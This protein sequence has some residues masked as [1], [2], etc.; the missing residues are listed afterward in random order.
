M[1]HALKTVFIFFI[2]ISVYS[3]SFV[4]SKNYFRWPV[5]VKPGIVAN[6]GELREGHW[7]MGLDIR[8]DHKVNTPVYA[9]AEGYIARVSVHAFGYGQAIYIN[10]PNGLTTVYGH[11]NKFFPALDSFVKLQQYRQ[12][13]WD[14]E[15]EFSKNELPVKKGQFIALSGSTGSSQGP[16]VHFEIRDTKTERCINPLLFDLPVADAVAPV[17]TKLAMYNRNLS[18]YDQSPALFTVN[19]RGD[20]YSVKPELIRTGFARLS[21]AVG[22]YDC[23]TGSTNRN[24]IYSGEIFFDGQR[25]IEFVLDSMDYIETEYVNA[26]VDYKYKYNGG[27]YLQQLFQLPGDHGRAYKPQNSNGTIVLKDTNV[28]SV[29][30][31]ARDVFNNMSELT[32]K[33]Q[34]SDRLARAAGSG[35]GSDFPPNE[36][37][38]FERDDF[39]VYL[40]EHCLYDSIPPSF[41]QQKQPQLSAVSPEFRFGDPSIPFYGKINIRIK[42]SRPITDNL[43]SRV[44]IKRTDKKSVSFRVATWQM[45]WLAAGFSDF[46]SYCAFVD[47]ELPVV[48]DLAKGDTIDL[49]SSKNIVFYPKDNSGVRTF[50]AELDGKWLRFTNDKGAA[51]IYNFD[52]RCSYGTHLL[53]IKIEDLVGNITEK[54]WWFRRLPYQPPAKKKSHT[55]TKRSGKTKLQKK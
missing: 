16:H 32:F 21:F 53:R 55:G 13:S 24:G 43:K 41:S 6:F 29:R 2:S 17:F 36:V 54:E 1:L 37:N 31:E 28:H 46:G 8:T 11:L 42:P 34:Y 9:A 52:E 7:H 30:I 50:T 40:P 23:V 48:N 22:A 15:L 44:V 12:E 3:Q 49:S 18:V 51:W 26:H 19:R 20:K 27:I 38:V 45:D 35:S 33:L 47:S 39:E 5:Q 10:H 14:I 25:L 4:Y